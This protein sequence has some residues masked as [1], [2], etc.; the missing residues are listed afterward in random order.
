[1][2]NLIFSLNA[3]IPVFLV[4]VLGFFLHQIGWIDDLFAQ[5]MN[6]FVFRVP[7]PVMLFYQLAHT[8]FRDA[9]DTKFVLF[10]FFVTLASITIAVLISRFLKD[11][12]ERGEFI[13]ASYRSSAAILGVAYI[14]NIYGDAGMAPLMMIGSVPLYNVMA[15]V[16]L[17]VT[18]PAANG[19]E[20]TESEALPAASGDAAPKDSS[21][22]ALSRLDPQLI[23]K[24]LRGIITNPIIL[25]ILAGL[26]WSLSGIHIPHII[27]KTLSEVGVLSTPLGLLAMGASVEPSKVSGELKPAIIASILKLVGFCAL[28]LP[29]AVSLGFRNQKLVAILIMLGSASTVTCFVMA[30]N[31]GHEGTLSTNAVMITTILSAFTITMWLFI[32]KSLGYL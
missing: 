4:M 15:V 29:L 10:C 26:L 32:L 20:G 6:Q 5:K 16:I 22:S 17:T 8:D 27:N 30:K 25:G 1:M 24:T 3:T 9:W 31:M 18:A 14:S 11:P 12:G 23:R 19:K 21:G 7:L 28:F 13:Q 2:A